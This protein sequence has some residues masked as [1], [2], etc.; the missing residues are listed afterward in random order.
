M[1]GENI[2]MLDKITL[3]SDMTCTVEF[4]D[5][6]DGTWD[7]DGNITTGGS[8]DTFKIDGKKLFYKR[9]DDGLVLE[10]TKE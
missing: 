8:K 6:I 10:F 7:T 2:E 4:Q 3:R 1:E 9:T 5:V